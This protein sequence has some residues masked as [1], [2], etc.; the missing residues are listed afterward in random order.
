[1]IFVSILLVVACGILW[2]LGGA[3]GFSKLYR[4]LG[5][6]LC[7]VLIV[8]NIYALPLLLWGCTSYMGWINNFLPVKDKDREY[9]WNFF[10]ENLV[11][12]LSILT[13]KRGLSNIVFAVITALIIAIGKVW[14]DKS[15]KYFFGLRKDVVSE[16]WHGGSNALCLLINTLL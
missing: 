8:G 14:I 12:Q 15:W 7:M 11:I 16:W 5:S 9:W 2:R 10:A 6:S 3:E 13:V 1:M 4:R